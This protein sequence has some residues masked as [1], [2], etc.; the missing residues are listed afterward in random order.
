MRFGR[1]EKAAGQDDG[2]SEIGTRL[3]KF[4]RLPT[5]ADRARLAIETAALVRKLPRD[6]KLM[7]AMQLAN[8]STEGNL[9]TAALSAVAV[10]LSDGLR[11]S[12]PLVVGYLALAK[13]VRYEH[14]APPITDPAL[15]AAGSLLA[16]RDGLLEETPFTLDSLDGATY[17]RASLRGKV[18]LLNFWATWCA[19]CRKEMPDLERL[20]REFA[21]RGLVVLAV[22]DEKRD[23]VLAFLAKTPYSFPILLDP[24]RKVHAGFQVEGIPKS[25]LFD[26]AGKLAAQAIDMRTEAQFRAMLRAA[27]LE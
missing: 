1:P 14:I 27:G 10:A 4:R 13:L 19:P 18:V 11:D 20:S 15:D 12:K 9:G 26:R 25:F 3:S 7:M 17:S 8:L 22:T 23:E 2:I 6:S 5:D 21:G 24:R 16:L